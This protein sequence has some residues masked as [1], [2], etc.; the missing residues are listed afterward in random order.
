MTKQ[1]TF[2]ILTFLLFS[3]KGKNGNEYQSVDINSQLKEVTNYQELNDFHNANKLLNTLINE[4]PNNAELYFRLAH[5]K[6][7]SNPNLF[8]IMNLLEQCLTRDSLNYKALYLK[9]QGL[10][11][12]GD[13]KGALDADKK[14]LENYPDS[15][16]LKADITSTL[17]FNGDFEKAI[18]FSESILPESP[19]IY[20]TERL[21]RVQVYAN[22]FLDKIE[23][24]KAG[25]D[26]LQQLGFET[27]YLQKLIDNKE[28]KFE[29]F[30]VGKNVGNKPCSLKELNIMFPKKN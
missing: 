6:T 27:D 7:V 13:F 12:M 30:A 15:F 5:S 24:V 14:L 16:V 25:K 19:S 8:E 29:D 18:E 28:L 21:I 9:S 4:N 1:I 20:E 3:C 2:I 23:N 22:Y 17:L 11:F 26:K 10:M